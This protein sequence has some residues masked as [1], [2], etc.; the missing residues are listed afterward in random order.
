MVNI[1][2]FLVFHC[3]ILDE[4]HFDGVI[5]CSLEVNAGA[6]TVIPA[7]Q[8]FCNKMVYF[9]VEKIAALAALS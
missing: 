3:G 8:C 7:W 5:L 2:V 4:V 6:I 1:S 9:A